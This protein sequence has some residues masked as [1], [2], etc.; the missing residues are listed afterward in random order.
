MERI[1][2]ITSLQAYDSVKASDM[3]ETHWLKIKEALG[4]IK[5]GNYEMIAD[6]A[7]L[8]RHAIG[9]R[10][11]EMCRLEMV[12][13]AGYT[14][15]TSTNRAAECY[16][17]SKPETQTEKIPEGKTITDFSKE[18]VQQDLFGSNT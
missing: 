13:K 5:V 7:G 16:Q 6:A 12:H 1:N 9:R 17:L 14:L 18:L 15:P 2:P 3:R 8:E 10:L 11:S 4:R